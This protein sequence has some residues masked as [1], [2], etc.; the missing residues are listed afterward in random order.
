MSPP[1]TSTLPPPPLPYHHPI[2]ACLRSVCP[3]RC[4]AKR[5][6][7]S[8][9]SPTWSSTWSAANNVTRPLTMPSPDSPW[10]QKATPARARLAL[11]LASLFPRLASPRP[12]QVAHDWD[13]HTNTRTREHSFG[14]RR[15]SY[16]VISSSP[17]PAL[18]YLV[19]QSISSLTQSH[20]AYHIESTL[21][22]L[23]CIRTLVG[24]RLCNSTRAR[25]DGME[26]MPCIC[27]IM[28]TR[29]SS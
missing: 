4:S 13:E 16:G 10:H 25:R 20:V 18:T 22:T 17:V 14:P 26:S 3:L 27:R 12:G 19:K 29:S 1:S 5:A 28:Q 11:H 15:R 8:T 23:P 24:L 9:W 6:V 21:H 2:L 7:P